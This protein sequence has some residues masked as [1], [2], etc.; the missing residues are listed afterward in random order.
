MQPQ[1][2]QD[3]LDYLYSFL[4]TERKL[5]PRPADLNL[6]RTVA[7]LAALG[8]PQGAFPSVVIAGTKGKGSTAAMT[9]AIARASGLRTG[10]WSSPHLHSYRERIQVNRQLI[11][12]E[13]LVE[14]VVAIQPTR[15][16][17]GHRALWPAERVRAWICDRAAL[18]SP[19]A[20]SIWPSS[21]SG[22]AGATI[23]PTR[24]RRC[25]R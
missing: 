2:Y 24:S 7:L 5:P 10:L 6:P 8:E 18:L 14:H 16:G 11:T 20:R 15:C 12:Q 25:S 13:E 21:R 9:E 17:I 22:W 3:A 19:R 4:D 1:T 23:A